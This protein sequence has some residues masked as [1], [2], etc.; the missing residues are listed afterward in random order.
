[1]TR[2]TGAILFIAMTNL[3][4]LLA[5]SLSI[6]SYQVA[7]IFLLFK[8]L[9]LAMS[10][11][12]SVSLRKELYSVFILFYLF[13]NITIYVIHGFRGLRELGLMCDMILTLALL[14]SF[15]N[16]KGDFAFLLV[17]VAVTNLFFGVLSSIVPMLFF[18]LASITGKSIYTS[19]RS[20]G[21]LL[22]PN[23]YGHYNFLLLLLSTYLL[24]DRKGALRLIMLMSSIAIVMSGSRAAILLLVLYFATL[25]VSRL[26]SHKGITFYRW[27]FM[28]T[29]VFILTV[30]VAFAGG[31]FDE[32]EIP[33]M[34][35]A[36]KNVFETGLTN[37]ASITERRLK[38]TEYYKYI[39]ENIAFGQGLGSQNTAQEMGLLFGAAHNQFLEILYQ[40]G[41]LFLIIIITPCIRIVINIANLELLKLYF[42]FSTL[43]LML[44]SSQILSLNIWWLCLIMFDSKNTFDYDI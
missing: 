40:G 25:I 7:G 6:S 12:K 22:Q 2:L 11:F 33:T 36:G 13:A 21:L 41:L 8:M 43:F 18:D 34:N 29:G 1:M 26:L 31:M 15:V 39:G 44:I 5:R 19:G 35:R 30:M 4:V 28:F 17:A 10:L 32:F 20:F 42:L 16:Q 27:Q 37:D 23:L 24:R 9:I 3:G 38:R 14:K